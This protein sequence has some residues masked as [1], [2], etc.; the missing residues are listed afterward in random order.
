VYASA[1]AHTC[2][3]T[4]L[5]ARAH[6]RDASDRTHTHAPACTPLPTEEWLAHLLLGNIGDPEGTLQAG[7]DALGVPHGRVAGRGAAVWG[8]RSLLLCRNQSITH[9]AHTHARSQE[10][11][12]ARST[13]THMTDGAHKGISSPMHRALAPPSARQAQAYARICCTTWQRG[14]NQHRGF[15]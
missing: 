5:R 8:W 11:L 3:H 12:C 14:T 2:T 4:H 10:Q 9:T 7:Q 15:T 6:T 13:S 1:C